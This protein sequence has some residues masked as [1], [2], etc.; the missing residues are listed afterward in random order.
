MKKL[1]IATVSA[2]T[3]EPAVR[4]ATH[5]PTP[6]MVRPDSREI[7]SAMLSES[8]RMVAQVAAAPFA[9][10]PTS[11]EGNANAAFI[12]RAVNAHDDLVKALEEAADAL[13]VGRTSKLTLCSPGAAARIESALLKATA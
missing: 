9:P 1:D 4:I 5:T 7:W 2:E 6:W 11:A 13:G 3:D 10:Y 12:V 8:N